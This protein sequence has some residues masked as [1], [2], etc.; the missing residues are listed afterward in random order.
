VRADRPVRAGAF[1]SAINRRPAWALL[2]SVAAALVT[3]FAGCGG[4]ASTHTATTVQTVRP[5]AS[6][7]YPPRT[8][9]AFL[10]SCQA[11]GGNTTDC[12][13]ALKHAEATVPLGQLDQD[14][15]SL[16]SGAP[17]QKLESPLGRVISRCAAAQAEEA[18]QSESG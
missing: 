17:Q 10:H 9:T 13:C 4:S 3:L 2:A 8:E 18:I 15:K 7:P 6:Q 5:T 1:R 12:H 14:E 16:A 11:F